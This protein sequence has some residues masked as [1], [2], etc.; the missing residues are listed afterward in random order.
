MATI[1][2][3]KDYTNYIQVGNAIEQNFKEVEI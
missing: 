2:I 3:T 1:L